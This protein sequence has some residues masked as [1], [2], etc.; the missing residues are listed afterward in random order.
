MK[1]QLRKCKLKIEKRLYDWG[2]ALYHFWRRVYCR[3]KYSIAAILILTLATIWMSGIGFKFKQIFLN[4]QTVVLLSC[5]NYTHPGKTYPS[6]RHI[7]VLWPKMRLNCFFDLIL[8]EILVILI[9]YHCKSCNKIHSWHALNQG[10][11]L[12]SVS[13][14]SVANWAEGPSEV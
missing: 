14:R 7:Q 13:D 2:Y 10:L 3:G 4:F 9:H 1:Y 8:R 5:P 6:I 11:I 12:D